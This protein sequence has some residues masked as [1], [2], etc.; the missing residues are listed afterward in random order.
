MKK[1]AIVTRQMIAGGIEKALIS[2]LEVIPSEKY[3]VTLFVMGSGGEFEKFIPKWV[4]IKNL[5]GDEKTII[6][7]IINKMRKGKFIDAFRIGFY[8]LKSLGARPGYQ[9]EKILAKILPKENEIFDLAIAYHVPASF[10]VVYVVEH[11]KAE[12]KVAWIHSDVE[13]YK[14]YLSNYIDYYSKFDKIYCVSEDGK[15]KFDNQYP[16]LSKK[17]EVFHNIINDKQLD[18]LS[19]EDQGF[20]DSFNGIRILTVARLT[21][22]KGCDILP[23]IVSKLAAKNNIRW[24]I[25]GDG[26]EREHISKE[27]EKYKVQ[28]KLILLGLKTNPYPYFKECD[29]YVQP[30]RHEGYCITLAE[31]RHFNKPI[32]TTNFVG[33]VEQIKNNETGLIVRFDEREIE[34]SIIKIVED[35]KLRDK[36][37]LNLNKSKDI[38]NLEI[39]KI[40]TLME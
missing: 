40:Y 11:L 7:K 20:K 25:I 14:R 16:N 12:K 26:E 23:R 1:I 28:D 6:E 18:K 15:A 34:E 10:P 29:I 9:Q 2:M 37:I 21:K 8:S 17:T 4:N 24:Y 38:N 39:E 22:Q 19:K 33:A 3:E 32:V 30:S 13:V 35:D 36:L 5:Y 31:A 27:I